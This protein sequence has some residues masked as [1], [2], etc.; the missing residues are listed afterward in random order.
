M[1]QPNRYLQTDEHIF[2]NAAST[3]ANSA[4][5][6]HLNQTCDG[7]RATALERDCCQDNTDTSNCDRS[8]R[9]DTCSAPLQSEQP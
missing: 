5:C 7:N 1:R 8:L 3:D 9:G 6:L 2:F 4:S